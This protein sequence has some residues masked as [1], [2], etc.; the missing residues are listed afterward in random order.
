MTDEIAVI[1]WERQEAVAEEAAAEEAA[2]VENPG[3]W[4][5]YFLYFLIFPDTAFV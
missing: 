4:C 3:L 2:V 1:Q 5:D